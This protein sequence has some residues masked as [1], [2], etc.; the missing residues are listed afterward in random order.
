VSHRGSPCRLSRSTPLTPPPF[1]LPPEEPLGKACV[2]TLMLVLARRG[3]GG[4][5][6]AP[7]LAVVHCDGE[8]RRWWLAAA[9]RLGLIWTH[10]G[11]EGIEL[12]HP[13]C[14]RFCLHHL[15]VVAMATGMVA[16]SFRRR[17]ATGYGGSRDRMSCRITGEAVALL[18]FAWSHRTTCDRCSLN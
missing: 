7:S 13:I 5:R 8:W 2:A 14:S 15:G 1:P 6:F 17:W 3:D 10:M 18:V 9:R 4:T 16:S 12:L 11:L